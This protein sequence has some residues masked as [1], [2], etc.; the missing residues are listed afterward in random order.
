MIRVVYSKIELDKGMFIKKI[1]NMICVRSLQ[2]GK[3]AAM[4][5]PPVRKSKN[6]HFNTP[7]C[8]RVDQSW[9]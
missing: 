2:E 4:V 7:I 9:E 6:K 3:A 5:L 8:R 1:K